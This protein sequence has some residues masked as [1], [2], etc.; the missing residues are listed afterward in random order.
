MLGNALDVQAVLTVAVAAMLSALRPAGPSAWYPV[1]AGVA[2]GGL[3]LVAAA[4]L[5]GT[6][7]ARGRLPAGA[8]YRIGFVTSG[9]L[10]ALAALGVLAAGLLSHATGLR[11][12][13]CVALAGYAAGHVAARWA[14]RA[15]E[16]GTAVRGRPAY[17]GLAGGNLAAAVGFT[18]LALAGT[19][20][21]TGAYQVVGVLVVLVLLLAAAGQVGA[22]GGRRPRT[23]AI[24]A[25]LTALTTLYGGATVLAVLFT[26]PSLVP[27][28]T[29]AAGCLALAAASTLAAAVRR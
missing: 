3:L 29:A 5:A 22:L 25:T 9:V 16:P 23:G 27:P 11:A 8:G 13:L 2:G 14:A 7:H 21:P 1:V 17:L 18:G 4:L 10:G 19:V 15:D 28:L 20:L 12:A 26:A 24:L 6:R